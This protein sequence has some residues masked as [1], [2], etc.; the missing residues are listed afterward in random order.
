MTTTSSRIPQWSSTITFTLAA[1]G[2]SVGL[3]N[4]WRFS[5]EAGA[6]GGGAFILVYLLCVICIGI[7]AIM[8]EFLIGRSGNASSAINSMRDVTQ[9]SGGSRWW[10]SSAW[11]GT[12]S[13]FLIASFYC[14]VAAWVMAYIP[15]FLNGAFDGQ[16]PAQIATQF[17]QMIVSPADLLPWFLIFGGLT[18]WLVARGVNRGI[19]LASKLLMPTFF[20]L[21]LLLS[22]Y[23]M[24]SSWESGGTQAALDF[25]FS[26][27]FSK[28]NGAVAVSALG[29]AFFSI[30][31]GMA[32]MVTYGSYLPKN[33]SLQRSA[34]IIGGSD[35]LVALIAGL[36]ISLSCSNTVWI[37]KRARACFFKPCLPRLL[38]APGVI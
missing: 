18:T 7:P 2:C 25:M 12:I 13:G 16:T 6:K 19:E 29:Q 33:V 28:I 10:V 36:A 22:L 3:G 14:V 24:I 32:M 1:I 21:L 37:L 17:N 26:A 5:A 8:C 9:R 20:L 31:L 23:S 11:A 27:D 38:P 4:L 35:T 30:G 34:L 15:K